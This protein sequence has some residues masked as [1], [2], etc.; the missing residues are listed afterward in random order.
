MPTILS[1]RIQKERDVVLVRQRAR[2][3]AALVGFDVQD[4]TRVA[5]AVSEIARNAF[6]YARNGKVEFHLEGATAPQLLTARIT[7]DGPGIADLAA[8]LS[9][10]YRSETGMGVGIIGARRL[11][12]QFEIASTPQNGTTVVLKQLLPS[13]APVLDAPA[14]AYVVAELARQAPEDAFGEVQ[15]QNQELLHALAELGRRQ[16]ELTA[17]NREL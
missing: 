16:E 10:S 4:Q 15:Q 9:G 12:D 1:L 3:V 6:E 7:D 5:T 11:V 14:I 8:I 13:R 17:V 2:Q